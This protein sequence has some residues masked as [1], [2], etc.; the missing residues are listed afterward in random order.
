MLS[1]DF[2]AKVSILV[3]DAEGLALTCTLMNA[4]VCWMA[5]VS[6]VT[7]A[8]DIGKYTMEWWMLTYMISLVLRLI[9]GWLWTWILL[10]YLFVTLAYNCFILHVFHPNKFHSFIG[11]LNLIASVVWIAIISDKFS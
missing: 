4:V 6:G 11:M 2:L 5:H 7:S 8:K 10:L 9:N 1:Y 3:T